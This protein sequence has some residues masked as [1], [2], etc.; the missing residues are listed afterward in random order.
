M[1]LNILSSDLYEH[2]GNAI[3]NFKATLPAV[4]S[5]LAQQITKAPYEFDFITL[6]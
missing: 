6:S 1:L 2:G 5:N 3:S 4:Q